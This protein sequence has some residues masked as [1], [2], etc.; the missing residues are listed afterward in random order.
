MLTLRTGCVACTKEY[1]WGSPAEK[2]RGWIQEDPSVMVIN[3]SMVP[4][5][6]ATTRRLPL[7]KSDLTF[8][9]LCT[10]TS[11]FVR[12]P[13]EADRFVGKLTLE[14][15]RF[16][17]Q[18]IVAWRTAKLYCKAASWQRAV[19]CRCLPPRS[20]GGPPFSCLTEP[21]PIQPSLR[22]A[23]ALWVKQYA[24]TLWIIHIY[25]WS[26]L[27]VHVHI[28]VRTHRHIYVRAHMRMTGPNPPLPDVPRSHAWYP[29]SRIC[30]P[31]T[32]CP[33]SAGAHTPSC[34]EGLG[35]RVSCVVG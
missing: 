13:Q 16:D 10:A 33:R 26:L 5:L 14:T 17:S 1:C 4:A 29:A 9:Y 20:P 30:V 31:A 27:H 22:A 19:L 24:M 28:Y 11:I 32:N 18:V 25:I 23:M 12:S 6:P 8:C 21:L 3:Q 7:T 15:G 2:L 34:V 35:L